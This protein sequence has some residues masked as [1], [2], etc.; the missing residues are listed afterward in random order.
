MKYVA[1][2]LPEDQIY[3]WF[4]NCL[5]IVKLYPNQSAADAH[6]LMSRPINENVI[7][8]KAESVVLFL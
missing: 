2:E 7:F 1:T 8:N 4:A 6:I 5:F 3:M